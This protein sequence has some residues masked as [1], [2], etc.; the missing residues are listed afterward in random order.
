MGWSKMITFYIAIGAIVALL[1][2]GGGP[3]SDRDLLD[4]IC[5]VESGCEEGA[6]GDGGNAIGPYQIWETYW[7]DAMEHDPSIGGN[8]EDC[9]CKDYSERVVL[10][11]WDRY[12]TE[13]RLGR[14]V[15][16]EDKA[17][18]H[19]GGPNGYKKRATLKYWDKVESNLVER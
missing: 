15:T 1:V 18:I 13:K 12:A 7:R 9:M 3:T 14:P 16:D 11:Y 19:N 4:S 5:Y 8:Y 6:I 2:D 10:S 17:R